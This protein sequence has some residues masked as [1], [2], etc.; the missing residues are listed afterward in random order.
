MRKIIFASLAALSLASCTA[1]PTGGQTIDI[2]LVQRIAVGA[3]GFLPTASTVLNI[4]SAGNALVMTAESVAGSI[5]A[6]ITAKASR[7][8][9]PGPS[10]NGVAIHGTYV[11][12]GQ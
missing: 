10:V 12:R 6:A 7:R 8:G 5:C 9:G 4:F 3:C 11:G 1:L 2:A